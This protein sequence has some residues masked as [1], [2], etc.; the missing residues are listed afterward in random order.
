MG[1]KM[2]Q[3]LP[4]PPKGRSVVSYTEPK[5]IILTPMCQCTLF[6]PPIINPERSMLEEVGTRSWCDME[7]IRAS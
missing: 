4:A 7:M 3:K 2:W 6:W 1:I 5:Q